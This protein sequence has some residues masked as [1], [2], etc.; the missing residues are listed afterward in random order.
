[1]KKKFLSFKK[2][3][4]IAF[5]NIKKE[6]DV[7]L[8]TINRNT[9]EIDRVYEAMSELDTK[10]EKLNERIDLLQMSVDP[11]QEQKEFNVD[12]THREQ[13]VFVLLYSQHDRV[14]AKD[15]ARR[16]GFTK[17]MVNRYVYN[18]VAKGI[19]VM[20]EYELDTLYV[21]LDKGFKELQA[22]N[23]VL[24]INESISRQLMDEKII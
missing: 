22:K 7:H 8:E 3:V 1:M 23:K 16:L 6:F 18:L 2:G 10:I 12:L 21:Y 24:T 5:E 13:E 19:P 9:D 17:E 15:V 4:K 20:K 11:K 14:K